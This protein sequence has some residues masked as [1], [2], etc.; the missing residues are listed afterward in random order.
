[1]DESTV[2]RF[3]S[4]V[5]TAD[6]GECWLWTPRAGTGGYGQ[7]YVAGKMR[8]AHRV[9]YEIAHGPIP[10]GLVVDHKCDIRNCVNPKHLKA[11]TQRANIHRARAWEAGAQAQ[12]AKTHCPHGHEYAGDNLALRRDGSRDCRACNRRRAAEQRKRYLE[13]NPRAPRVPKT[14]CKSGHEFTVE[15]TYVSPSNGSRTCREC[16]RQQ[17][18]KYRAT[19]KQLPPRGGSCKWGHPFDEVNTY[20]DPNGNRNCK[21]CARARTNEWY[22]RKKAAAAQST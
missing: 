8:L 2:Q 6:P 3:W 16:K 12:R 4:K 22:A 10:S 5:Q 11:T 19:P 1:M 18:K 15:N 14:H 17:V 20:I 21:A 9:A 13:A 7:L